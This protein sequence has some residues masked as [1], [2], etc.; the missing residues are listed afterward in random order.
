MQRL[1]V[2]FD[3]P[4]PRTEDRRRKTEDRRLKTRDRKDPRS[5][6][7]FIKTTKHLCAALA[8]RS[9]PGDRF[10]SS[11]SWQA[12]FLPGKGLYQRPG[13]GTRGSAGNIVTRCVKIIDFLWLDCCWLSKFNHNMQHN[14]RTGDALLKNN[15]KLVKKKEGSSWNIFYKLDFLLL[16]KL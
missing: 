13:G 6:D 8:C 11:S 9:L 1:D 10:E 16:Y 4:R 3:S 14:Q 15:V 5:R 12:D 2:F 7:V